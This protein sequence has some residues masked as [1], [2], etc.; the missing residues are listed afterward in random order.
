M[1]RRSP[2]SGVGWPATI[3]AVARRPRLW[4]T[5]LGQ[6]RRLARH[7]WWATPPFLPV[8]DRAWLRFRLETQYGDPAHPPVADDVVTWLAWAHRNAGPPQA[9]HL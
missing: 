1:S 6:A 3:A 9:P 2:G 7:R 8:P 4:P 5:A